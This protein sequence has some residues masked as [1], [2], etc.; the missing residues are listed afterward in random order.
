MKKIMHLI[1][2]KGSFPSEIQD[3][4]QLNL[5]TDTLTDM[6][7]KS[8]LEY[9]NQSIKRTTD[10]SRFRT[11]NRIVSSITN[12]FVSSNNTNNWGKV[13]AKVSEKQF[14]RNFVN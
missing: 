14:N 3:T 9:L 5:T 10:S 11:Q 2:I 6:D 13:S 8:K 1:N 7:Y 4:V 12:E